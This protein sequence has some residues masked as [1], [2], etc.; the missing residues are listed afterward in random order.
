L[1]DAPQ[2]GRFHFKAKEV[3]GFAADLNKYFNSSPPTVLFGAT[4][5]I[6]KFKSLLQ[7]K[8]F[9]Q[10]VESAPFEVWTSAEGFG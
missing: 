1:Q 2:I 8:I 7:P 10:F 6:V 9:Q 4:S 5:R 3:I